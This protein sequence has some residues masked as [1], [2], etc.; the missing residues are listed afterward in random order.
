ML[1]DRTLA[2]SRSR[3]ATCA[4]IRGAIFTVRSIRHPFRLVEG[5]MTTMPTSRLYTIHTVMQ[6]IEVRAG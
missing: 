4:P 6:I 2:A 3:R 5:G 1:R